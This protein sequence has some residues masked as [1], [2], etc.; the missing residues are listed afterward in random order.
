MNIVREA[1]RYCPEL[2]FER[3]LWETFHKELSCYEDYRLVCLATTSGSD[4]A[5]G[6]RKEIY[7]FYAPGDFHPVQQSGQTFERLNAL[8][9]LKLNSETVL[10]YVLLRIRFELPIRFSQHRLTDG[11]ADPVRR[12]Q[13]SLAEIV[14]DIADLSIDKDEL[15]ERQQKT[16]IGMLA[17]ALI[18]MIPEG[19]DAP[20][21]VER[22]DE[23]R[24]SASAVI[25]EEENRCKLVRVRVHIALDG[26]LTEIEELQ[27]HVFTPS[28][29]RQSP[30]QV[31][32]PRRTRTALPIRQWHKLDE[33]L[34]EP[35]RRKL[36]R[37]DPETWHDALRERYGVGRDD[38]AAAPILR[39][40]EMSFYKTFCLLE[41][42]EPR[43]DY[44][45]RTYA[46]IRRD[47]GKIDIR[48]LNG[49]SFVILTINAEDDKPLLDGAKIDDYLRFFCWA[50]QAQDGPFYLPHDIRELPFASGPTGNTLQTLRTLASPGGS[51]SIREVDD[52][53]AAKIG[54]PKTE[55]KRRRAYVVYS[56][57]MFEAW[58][59]ITPTG[60]VTMVC[61]QQRAQNL[62][63]DKEIFDDRDLFAL[64]P[65]F[66][67]DSSSGHHRVPASGQGD[68]A[69]RPKPRHYLEDCE[70]QNTDLT[71][72]SGAIPN[73]V[74][75]D[76][77]ALHSGKDDD[78]TAD[79]EERRSTDSIEFWR[80][81]IKGGVV[82]NRNIVER[83]VIDSPSL[84]SEKSDDN[85]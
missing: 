71:P 24:V 61:D 58:F 77:S 9:P 81:V 30:P 37:I 20:S 23:F 15:D 11:D 79:L 17:A 36:G 60:Q 39:V 73:D 34:P 53:E 44:Y 59:A 85:S 48:P 13:I 64:D 8:A 80:E 49:E 21:E 18:E 29:A 62:S 43:V 75:T 1:I 66:G 47:H 69:D 28:S 10:E 26:K 6:P 4:S 16:L 78:R 83:I 25:Q 40:A 74:A 51:F 33:R 65:S 63:I 42:L 56:T 32:F 57:G 84:R 12:R 3:G 14:T 76:Q 38:A 72:A 27:S 50:V 2:P 41:V 70:N 54:Y 52:D 31:L 7:G 5:V 19:N 46:L 22:G 45:R 67:S 35:L 68:A 82:S 55:M